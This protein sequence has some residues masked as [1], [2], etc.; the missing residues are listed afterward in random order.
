MADETDSTTGKK[1]RVIHWNPEA[2]RET[3][4]RRWTFKRIALWTVGGFFGLLVAAGIVIRVAKLVLGP[5]IFQGGAAVATAAPTH[6]DASQAFVSQS[7]AELAH[8]TAAKSLAELKRLPQ[9]HPVQLERLILITKTFGEGEA[10]LGAHEWARAFSTFEALA[11]DMDTFSRNVKAKQEAQQGYDAILL[12]IKDLERARNLAPGTLEAAFEN[13]GAGRKLL[14]DGN[15]LQAKKT[16]D[17]GFAELKKAEQALADKVQENLLKGQQALAKGDK[18]GAKSAFSAAMALSPG[19]ELAAQGMKRAENIDRVHALLLQGESQEK[20]AQY[21]Q[22]AESYQKAFALDAMSANAQAGAARASRLE[23]ETKFAAAFGAAQAALKERDW[24]KAIAE[25]QAAQKIYP[26]KTDVVQ[27]LRSARENAHRDAVQKA[28]TKGYAYENNH[29]WKEAIDAYR[30][31]LQLEPENADAKEAHIRCGTMIRTLIE[32]N[33]LVDS[34]KQL[35]NNSEFQGAIK[36]FTKAMSMRPNYPLPND[37]VVQQLHTVLNAQSKPV[38]VVFKSDGKTY[39]SI[40]NFRQPQ[41][42]ENFTVKI[43]PGDYQVIGRRK[44]Y[45]DVL[46]LLQVRNDGRPTREVTVICSTTADR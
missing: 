35:T 5:Q 42:S 4:Q 30:E 34:A 1:R 20:Q 18:E 15:F 3:Q 8:A 21:A 11:V 25:L 12:R 6:G 22:A 44:G 32:Y 2:G 17:D 13:A 43:F 37:D 33:S 14:D 29:Q 26:Q 41:Q 16:F 27:M 24:A 31:T 28:L 9:D 36:V 38:D 19:N 10:L 23:K 45:K 40:A 39:V 46:M 7:K